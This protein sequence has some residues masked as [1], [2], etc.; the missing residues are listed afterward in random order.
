VFSVLAQA[1]ELEPETPPDSPEAAAEAAAAAEE[2]KA[3]ATE[4]EPSGRAVAE[5]EPLA[6]APDPVLQELQTLYDAP[7]QPET[8]APASGE[9]A[10]GTGDLFQLAGQTLV[11]LLVICGVIILGGVV[12]R[13]FL[14]RTPALAGARLGHVLGRVYLSPKV[15]LHYVKSGG[16]VLVLGVTPTGVQMLTEFAADA[17][18]QALA[19]SE[20]STTREASPNFVEYLNRAQRPA[21]N[22]A[23]DDD[24]SNLRG[25]I[26]RLSE[27]LRD[28]N[29]EPHG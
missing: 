24:I 23:G 25:E 28:A 14:A 12:S 2:A 8:S 7:T 1:Q 17:F 10:R 22:P 5:G 27:F 16:R 20:T 4:E 9:R 11:G 13:R 6:A 15:S 26:Q 21:A 29:R 3:E 19:E 18:E